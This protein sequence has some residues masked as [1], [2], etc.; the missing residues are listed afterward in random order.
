MSD[1]HAARSFI[2]ALLE[3]DP[4]K[5]MTM[6]D[7]RK[8]PWLAA[9]TPIHDLRNQNSDSM[10]QDPSSTPANKET[11]DEAPVPPDVSMKSNGDADGEAIVSGQMDN[12]QLDAPTPP[13]NKTGIPRQGSRLERRSDVLLRAEEEG[14]ELLQPSQEMVSR[15]EKQRELQESEFVQIDTIEEGSSKKRPF[16]DLEAV[17]E[18]DEAFDEGELMDIA[19]P[20]KRGRSAEEG[21]EEGKEEEE[22]APPPSKSEKGKAPLSRKKV[23]QQA[24]SEM[25]RPTRRSARVAKPKQA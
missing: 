17:D 11:N 16:S 18:V 15:E 3:T 1:I 5:R 4:T 2:Q 12:L 19:S 20:R 9:Y 24:P 7:S 8:H 13:Q 23:Q 14:W 10:D 22:G 25:V 6:V 21:K